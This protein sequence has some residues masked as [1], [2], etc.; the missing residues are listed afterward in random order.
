MD[1]VKE[2]L[3]KEKWRS[4]AYKEKALQAHE[5]NVK[6]KDLLESLRNSD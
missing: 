3:A 1:K 5:R 6:A 2:Q 4:N